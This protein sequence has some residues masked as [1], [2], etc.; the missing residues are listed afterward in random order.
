MAENILAQVGINNSAKN[1]SKYG[2]DGSV[3]SPRD[4]KQLVFSPEPKVFELAT[5]E[6][7]DETNYSRLNTI[8]LMHPT[9]PKKQANRHIKAASP[10]NL[11]PVIPESAAGLE[12]CIIHT[13]NRDANVSK[14]SDANHKDDET[15]E[16]EKNQATEGS[17]KKRQP[18]FCPYASAKI[19][20]IKEKT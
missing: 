1:G 7:V 3:M 17:Q 18:Y 4:R 5:Q 15:S 8:P 6:G 11:G 16:K 13:G 20:K 9:I 19:A 12:N 10:T 14:S 2:A